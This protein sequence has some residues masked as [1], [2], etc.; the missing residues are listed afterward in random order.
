[1]L[2]VPGLFI[3]ESEGRG[4]GVFTAQE[5]QEGDIIEI[6]PLIMIPP[7][8]VPIMDKTIVHDYYFLDPEIPGGACIALGYGSIYNHNNKPNAEIRVDSSNQNMNIECIRPIHPGDE[9]FIDYIGSG[10][11]APNLWFI[12]V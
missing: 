9:I 4:R 6:C 12:P 10:K 3:A 2:H 8:E 11:N 7:Q 1:M 5:L